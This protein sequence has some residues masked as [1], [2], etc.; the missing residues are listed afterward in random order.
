MVLP[1]S[2]VN[3]SNFPMR[4]VK[5]TPRITLLFIGRLMK[6]KGIEELLEAS[7]IL[8]NKFENIDFKFIGFTDDWDER[9]ILEFTK[10][11]RIVYLGEQEDVRPFISET[12][13]IIHPSYHEGLSNV[14][15]EGAAM[16][17]PLLASNIPGC[18][19]II[20]DG[21]N[22]FLFEPRSSDAIVEAVEKFMALSF[23][24]RQEMGRKS[25]EKV[26]REFDR[27]IVV[28]AYMKEIKRILEEN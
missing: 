3:V 15:L 10:D 1:G 21:V 23:E 7:K 6:D 5:N 27:Q 2:G 12:S 26:E 28:D 16:G 19:E 13:A 24:E 14:L 4:F 18:K 22:G 9:K 11:D 17:R 20:D 25:R 8:I